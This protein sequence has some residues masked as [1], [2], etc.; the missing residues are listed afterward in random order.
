M[1]NNKVLDM[2][3]ALTP[4]TYKTLDIARLHTIHTEDYED[5]DSLDKL[6]QSGWMNGVVD[7]ETDECIWILTYEGRKLL[8][9]VEDIVL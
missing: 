4:E 9:I 6:Y 7:P 8:E 2:I 5:L 1:I 3:G